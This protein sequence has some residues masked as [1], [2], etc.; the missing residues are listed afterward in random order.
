LP[1]AI[2]AQLF[3]D[4]RIVPKLPIF[5]QQVF[6]RSDEVTDAVDSR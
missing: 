1:D 6:S 3:I 4:R 5:T 2:Y